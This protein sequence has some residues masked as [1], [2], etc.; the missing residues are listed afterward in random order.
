[1]HQKSEASANDYDDLVEEGDEYME[2]SDYHM[3]NEQHLAMQQGVS[4]FLE[5][6]EEEHMDSILVVDDV[7]G[8]EQT[9]Y[10]A[11]YEI[12]VTEENANMTF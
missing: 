11:D 6:N 4:E 1:M 8:N 12:G 10:G 3:V 2:E 9:L 5:I 7:H